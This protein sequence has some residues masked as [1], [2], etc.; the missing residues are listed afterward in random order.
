M[1]KLKNLIIIL[2]TGV[3]T[4]NGQ[5]TAN[6]SYSASAD[7]LTFTNQSTVSNAHF[8]WNFGDG[9]G[10]NDFSPIH[11]FPDD[12]DYLVTLYG[13]DTVTNC[14]D[15]VENWINVIKPDTFTCTIFF[16][17]TIIGSSPQT[18]NLSTNCSGY[19]LDCHVFAN[20][21]NICNG[22]SCAGWSPALFLHGMQ[23][24][25]YDS[26]NGYRIF[27]A[28]YETLPYN[29]LS[30]SNY[31][32]CS[33]N[34]ELII[35]YQTNGAL[36]TLTAMNKSGNSTFTITGF[37][38]PINL[39][40]LT[41]SYLYP[42]ITY[43]KVFP[44]LIT[45][46]KSDVGCSSV[47]STQCVLICNPYYT[48]PASCATSLQPQPQTVVTGSTVQF[49]VSTSPNVVKQWQQDAGL[50]FVNLSN[51]G[52]YSGVNTDTLT[53]TNVQLSMN[54]YYYRCV[55]SDSSGFGC[56]NT[57]SPAAL[58]VQTVGINEIELQNIKIHPN[59]TS[60]YLTFSLPENISSAEI[61]IF[62]PLGELEFSSILRNSNTQIDI[63]RL[64]NGIHILEITSGKNISRGKFI[65][66]QN[67]R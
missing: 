19:N 63:S 35:N 49:I 32:N 16:T 2:V 20:A 48:W 31:Q 41:V 50:G 42:Y 18:T 55:I 46:T 57:T 62:N 30:S 44:W 8:Y 56:H 23:A 43:A 24:T 52:P 14:V 65:K 3:I 11:I 59:P 9:S 12:G 6:Y 54:N 4:A 53:I 17:D 22:F 51:A 13:V 45:H 67:I 38:N 5:C 28:Y 27:H 36:V 34:F 60:D 15:V 25:D 58:N 33:A 37:G 26:I 21:Q 66:Q 7:T 1:K 64:I 29:Y 40:G 61:K 10:S 39:P 47:S